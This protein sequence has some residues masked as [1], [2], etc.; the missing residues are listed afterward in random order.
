MKI[1]CGK[2]GFLNIELF[3]AQLSLL[4]VGFILILSLFGN[5]KFCCS[6]CSKPKTNQ[7]EMEM[8]LI[9]ETG[10]IDVFVLCIIIFIFLDPDNEANQIVWNREWSN[11][12]PARSNFEK[13][14]TRYNKFA[15][16]ID[17]N[18]T[19]VEVI[20]PEIE[21]ITNLCEKAHLD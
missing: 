19:Q 21:Q 1:K 17:D 9:N 20:E 6:K 12:W 13:N 11:S 8:N 5:V 16:F 4:I 10:K 7:T 14:F 18:Q 3:D 2:K 15:T